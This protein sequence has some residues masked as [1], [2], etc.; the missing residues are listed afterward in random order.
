MLASMARPAVP[1]EDSHL[2]SCWA[3]EEV[4]SHWPGL[5]SPRGQQRSRRPTGLLPLEL[6]KSCLGAET[7]TEE[8]AACQIGPRVHCRRAASRGSAGVQRRQCRRGHLHGRCRGCRYGGRREGL[9]A[10]RLRHQPGRGRAGLG[11]GEAGRAEQ[12]R[13]APEAPVLGRSLLRAR[14]QAGETGFELDGPQLL[15]KRDVSGAGYDQPRCVA[16][17]PDGWRDRQEVLL[18]V[19]DARALR[20]NLHKDPVHGPAAPQGT[21]KWDAPRLGDRRRQRHH[22]SQRGPAPRHRDAAGGG[23]DTDPDR[24]EVFAR[25]C[26][27]DHGRS[28]R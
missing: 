22:R 19:A 21:P 16:P 9:R 10:R 27:Q 25:L 17:R 2:C 13:A 11:A 14:P 1:V 23:L 8:G 24:A 15:P 4:L 20:G 18:C 6:Q 26:D 3:S 7:P 5:R 12:R 28:G